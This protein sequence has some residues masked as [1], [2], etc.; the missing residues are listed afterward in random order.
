VTRPVGKRRRN[1]FLKALA[2]TGCITRAAQRAG[3]ARSSMY[4]AKH[5]DPEF[6]SAW[7]AAEQ[8]GA[9][10]LE[11]EAYRRAVEG[12]EQPV[13]YKGE[14]CGTVTRYSDRLLLALMRAKKPEYRD[15]FEVSADLGGELSVKGLT[16]DQLMAIAAK[17]LKPPE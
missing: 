9:D 3:V 5:R 6:A 7:A 15:R 16:D 13:Y 17:G 14:K 11:A 10:V 12:V 1:A 8:E 4:N 2:E